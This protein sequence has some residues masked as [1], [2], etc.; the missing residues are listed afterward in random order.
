MEIEKYCRL[1]DDSI[2]TLKFFSA[3]LKVHF[4]LEENRRQSTF[5]IRILPAYTVQNPLFYS[6]TAYLIIGCS[7]IVSGKRAQNDW[8]LLLSKANFDYTGCSI[9]A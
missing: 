7:E 6:N 3:L 2:R 8:L 1:V 5:F 4:Y 9:R